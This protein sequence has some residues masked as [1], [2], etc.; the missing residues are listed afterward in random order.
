[1]SDIFLSYADEDKSRA[2]Q[3]ADSLGRQGWS[4]WWDKKIPPGQ[5][6]DT[7]IQKALDGARC[8]VVLWT[9]HSTSSHWVKTEA[10]EGAR[11]GI[12]VPALMEKVDLPLEFRRI[13]S[14]DLTAWQGEDS[15]GDYADFLLAIGNLLDTPP[16]IDSFTEPVEKKATPAPDETGLSSAD[17][18]KFDLNTWY[19]HNKLVYLI[20]FIFWPVGLYGLYKSETIEKKWKMWWVFAF[21]AL[22]FIIALLDST[23][24]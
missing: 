21:V 7:V 16:E 18:T 9:A 1:M 14:A 19:N 22:I 23:T 8:V 13:Q 17:S 12:L 2:K 10:A 3:L 11:R 5:S 15:K 24:Y 4:V 20:I 6:F